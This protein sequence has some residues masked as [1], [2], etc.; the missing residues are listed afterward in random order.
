MSQV[1]AKGSVQRHM[2]TCLG[3]VWLRT[4]RYYQ[5]GMRIGSQPP[6][7]ELKQAKAHRSSSA[8][9]DADDGVHVAPP[10]FLECLHI[11]LHPPSAYKS[12]GGLSCTALTDL[13]CHV[14]CTAKYT[15]GPGG[16]TDMANMIQIKLAGLIAPRAILLLALEQQALQH[17]GQAHTQQATCCYICI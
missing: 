2:D 7:H 3:L 4:A 17:D 14:H 11:H 10:H 12:G 15:A 6:A 16:M 8:R 13:Y 9:L 5:C 1:S